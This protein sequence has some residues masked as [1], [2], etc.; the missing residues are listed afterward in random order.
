VLSRYHADIDPHEENNSHSAMLDMVGFNKRVLETGCASGHMSA[1]LRSQGCSVVGV[2][3][4]ASILEPAREWLERVVIGDVE[5]PAL[6]KEFAGEA[7]DAILFGDVLEHLRNPLP[8]LREAATH[9]A[10]S[11]V[12]VIS[13]PNIAH[14]DVKTALINGAFPYGESGLLDRTHLSF[15]T[16]DSLIDLVR[17]A[18]LAVVEIRR[19]TVPV[20]ATELGVARDDIDDAT[21]SAITHDREAETYQFVVKAV[22]DDAEHAIN[23]LSVDLIDLSDRLLDESKNNAALRVENDQLVA[24][25]EALEANRAI[26]ERDL[27]NLRA[28]RDTIKRLLPGPLRRLLQKRVGLGSS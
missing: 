26:N 28:Q 25:V 27:A 16:K 17:E 9:L 8:A 14:A 1:Q 2:E 19:I 11:G 4:E 23:K 20:F 12:V 6:W 3:I 21:L 13:V 10:D 15:F 18:G 22:R 5:D 7:F 24:Q